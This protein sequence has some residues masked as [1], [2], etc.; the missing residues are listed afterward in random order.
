MP[1]KDPIR[2]LMDS[3][4]QRIE[5]DQECPLCGH[6][7]VPYGVTEGARDAFFADIVKLLEVAY[8]HV[9]EMVEIK[10]QQDS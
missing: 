4:T 1:E 5:N 10:E 9:D 8:V 3:W 2:E 7:H 6:D